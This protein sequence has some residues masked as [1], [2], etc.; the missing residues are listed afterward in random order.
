V[1]PIADWVINQAIVFAPGLLLA[2]ALRQMW[3]ALAA[4]SRRI[5]HILAEHARDMRKE[6]P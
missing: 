6:T 3:R 4:A 1:S 2:L 5:D